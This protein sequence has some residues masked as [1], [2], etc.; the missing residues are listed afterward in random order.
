MGPSLTVILYASIPDPCGHF[1]NESGIIKSPGYPYQYQNEIECIYT[2]EA[3]EDFII[4]IEIVEFDLEEHVD[5]VEFRDGYS[6]FSPLLRTFCGNVNDSHFSIKTVHSTQ[7][8]L[9]IR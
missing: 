9:W 6:E 7:T 8:K 4:K 1:T 2:I 3:A 5:C